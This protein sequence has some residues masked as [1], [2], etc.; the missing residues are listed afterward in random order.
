MSAGERMRATYDFR[1]VDHLYRTEFSI[2]PEAI[3]RWKG[4]GLPED[5]QE[6]NL[7]MYDAQAIYRTGLNLGW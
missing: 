4:E 3:E 1:P 5:W 7:F 6:T 2:W